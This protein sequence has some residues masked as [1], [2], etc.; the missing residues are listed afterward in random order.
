[1]DTPSSFIPHEHPLVGVEECCDCWIISSAFFP[2]STSWRSVSLWEIDLG[3][4]VTK[5]V[6]CAVAYEGFQNCMLY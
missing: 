3:L 1:M 2:V 5:P 6:L 4:Q